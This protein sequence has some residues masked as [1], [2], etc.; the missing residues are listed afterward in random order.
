M[1]TQSS[2]ESA[3]EPGAGARVRA[4][5]GRAALPYWVLFGIALAVRL[6]HHGFMRANS[7]LYC[8]ILPN[9]DSH[10][11][12]RWALEISQTFWLGWN[13]I[14]F[15]Q[16]PLYP[17]FL[18][19]NYLRF[20]YD[21]P[22]AIVA[23][24]IVG[25]LT[26]LLVF[27]LAKRAFGKAE[28]WIAGLAAAFCPIFL[29]YEG[30]ILSDSFI[31]F[32]A[33]VVLRLAVRAGDRNTVGAWALFGF[34]LGASA[35][36]RPNILLFG[37]VAALWCWAVQR[38]RR[39]REDETSE[40]PGRAALRRVVVFGVVA[41]ATIAPATALNYAKGG[42][43]VLVSTNGPLCLYTGNAYDATGTYARSPSM[44][45]IIDASP[46]EEKDIPWMTHL[47]R[48]IREHPGSV[49]RNLWR[50]TRLF[51]QSGEIPHNLNFYLMRK[52]SPFLK[53][54]ITFGV[55]TPLAVAGIVLTFVRKK[56]RRAGGPRVIMAAFLATYYVSVIVFFVVARYRL[57]ATAVMM[58]FAAHG[59]VQWVGMLNDVLRRMRD[60]SEGGLGAACAKAVSVPVL[61]AVVAFGL[62]TTD[63]AL[64]V[65]WND[66]YNLAGAYERL[67]RFAEAEAEYAEALK[68]APESEMLKQARDSAAGQAEG[69][70]VP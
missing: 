2:S 50:K 27:S 16:G 40:P 42:R 47:V 23:Q 59:V 19:L 13:R 45:D 53:A 12:D 63:P 22:A 66:H 14:P 39:V 62:R 61:C 37:P 70:D 31:F 8:Y 52:F 65:R 18:G 46:E 54:P 43:F 55:I 41:A 51:W 38:E 48:S 4:L 9:G 35:L 7:P 60:R 30:E 17:Y 34:A 56:E 15:Y 21:Q 49:P 68:L 24:H 28:A 32:T 69:T 20:G 36:A 58:P 29:L 5:F 6:V 57:T 64:L 33:M 1:H 11:F 3:V 25:A 26:V 10:G 67:G 44:W